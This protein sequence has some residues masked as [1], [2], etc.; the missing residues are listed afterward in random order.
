MALK[1]FRF[2][3]LELGQNIVIFKNNFYIYF[4][5]KQFECEQQFFAYRKK[6]EQF[7]KGFC[8]VNDSSQEEN[9]ILSWF[10]RKKT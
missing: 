4:C 7:E 10:G 5:L 2:S 8:F 3:D 1:F 9:V 6:L